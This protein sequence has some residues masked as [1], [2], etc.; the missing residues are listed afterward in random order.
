MAQVT[1]MPLGWHAPCV[2]HSKFHIDQKKYQF[3]RHSTPKQ[4]SFFIRQNKLFS[5]GV[6]N[7]YGRSCDKKSSLDVMLDS[8]K[9][10]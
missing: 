1:L 7:M 10:F 6:H 9:H 4:M 8:C 5:L 2:K 3:N